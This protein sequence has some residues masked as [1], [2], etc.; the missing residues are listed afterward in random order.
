MDLG[1]VL[2]FVYENA[3]SEVKH[4]L[5]GNVVYETAATR[6]Y[7]AGG[8]TNM[9][10]N[11][12]GDFTLKEWLDLGTIFFSKE[13]LTR[14]MTVLLFDSATEP[15]GG[16]TATNASPE[17][18]SPSDARGVPHVGEKTVPPPSPDLSVPKVVLHFVRSAAR[19]VRTA[20]IALF[21]RTHRP[22]ASRGAVYA[23]LHNLVSTGKLERHGSSS[24]E[25]TFTLA[26]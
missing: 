6:F 19:S 18:T 12:D 1:P 14:M 21:V 13:D 11:R 5:S 26:K 3:P 10:K 15:V 9:T 16:P 25:Y 2:I 7:R 4:V 20:E 24:S 22:E 23:A 17:A 8:L